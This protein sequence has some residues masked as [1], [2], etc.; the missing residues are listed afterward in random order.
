MPLVEC[1]T[2]KQDVADT[3]EVCPHCGQDQPE[4]DFRKRPHYCVSCPHCR[5]KNYPLYK[6]CRSCGSSLEEV[7]DKYDKRRWARELP[8]TCALVGG[9]VCLIGGCAYSAHVL[10]HANRTPEAIG[11][12]LIGA[13][14]G[15][16]LGAIVGSIYK[17]IHGV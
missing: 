17:S 2:C 7:N 15:W 10:E 11:G 14:A 3:A 8:S 16:V 1:V 12:A 9:V 4:K 13:L 5:V 6:Q